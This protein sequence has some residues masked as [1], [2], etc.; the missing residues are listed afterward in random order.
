MLRFIS[1]NCSIT[2]YNPASPSTDFEK[3]VNEEVRPIIQQIHLIE[4]IRTTAKSPDY[5][6]SAANSSERIM[7]DLHKARLGTSDKRCPITALL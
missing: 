3:I 6:R 4:Q 7:L 2:S 1:L 5:S